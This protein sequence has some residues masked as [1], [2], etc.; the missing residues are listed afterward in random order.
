MQLLY[1]SVDIFCALLNNFSLKSIPQNVL[2]MVFEDNRIFA[3]HQL[4]NNHIDFSAN[5]VNLKLLSVHLQKLKLS[6]IQF[7]LE[8]L[9]FAR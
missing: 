5:F 4:I 8:N 7:E 2:N 6:S 9:L 3:L 1:P